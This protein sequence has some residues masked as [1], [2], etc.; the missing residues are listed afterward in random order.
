MNP[1]IPPAA[2]SSARSVRARLTLLTLATLVGSAMSLQVQAATVPD[3]SEAPQDA[4]DGWTGHVQGSREA[5]KEAA[6][7]LV[8]GRRE[9]GRSSSKGEARQA[10]LRKVQA[11]YAATLK[12]MQSTSTARR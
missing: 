5:R 8:E 2:P 12:R 3:W 9:C 10:C 4:V 6:A 11:D 1:S 7:A